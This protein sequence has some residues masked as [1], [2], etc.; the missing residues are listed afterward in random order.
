[1]ETVHKVSPAGQLFGHSSSGAKMVDADVFPVQLAV[2][3][4]AQLVLLMIM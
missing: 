3:C 2:T 1:M 4:A